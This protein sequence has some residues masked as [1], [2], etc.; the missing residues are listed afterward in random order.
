MKVFFIKF[1]LTLCLVFS[2]SVTCGASLSSN[3]WMTSSGRTYDIRSVWQWSPQTLLD[4]NSAQK[5]GTVFVIQYEAQ[6]RKPKVREYQ[7]IIAHYYEFS[8][9]HEVKSLSPEEKKRY[10]LM[11]E[12]VHSSAGEKKQ[13]AK[14]SF[15]M[16]LVDV[17]KNMDSWK[18]SFDQQRYLVLKALYE[19]RFTEAES[20]FVSLRKKTAWDYTYLTKTLLQNGN[21]ASAEKIVMEGLDRYPDNVDLL[22]Q[23][24]TLLTLEGTHVTGGKLEY[25][26]QKL[27]EARALF[28]KILKAEKNDDLAR[29]H[30]AAV[31]AALEDYEKAQKNYEFLISR[32]PAS[33]ITQSKLAEVYRKQKKFDESL[34][35]YTQ[36]LQI[37]SQEPSLYW[38]VAQTY[39]E[40]KEYPNAIRYY[41][42][43]LGLL[44]MRSI[45]SVERSN[46]EFSKIQDQLKRAK[47]SRPLKEQ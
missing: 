37:N 20:G 31:F 5:A 9:P 4:Q 16:S 44:T 1:F 41:H 24:A 29:F 40:K 11:V 17:E 43:T 28:E 23:K 36:A 8:L 15:Y 13:E 7:D 34:R 25:D 3:T 32:D 35:Y 21:S 19:G 6:R 18:K 22:H 42:Y 12:T 39:H 27:Q 46:F 47:K 38:G 2:F 14:N 45:G 10:F 26:R 30:L 33:W